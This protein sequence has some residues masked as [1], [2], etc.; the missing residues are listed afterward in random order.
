M[1]SK[2]I[3]VNLSLI[4]MIAILF[5][6]ATAQMQRLHM[7]KAVKIPF[8]LKHKD[9]VLKKGT[10]EFE[11]LR[12][13]AAPLH[14]LRIRKGGKKL[15]LIQGEPW[16]YS[17]STIGSDQLH[18]PNVPDDPRLRIKKIPEEKIVIITFETCKKARKYPF[19]RLRFKM[20]Y[21]E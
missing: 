17:T 18:D 8:K 16:T 19:I 20:E 15:C 9:T 11:F 6:P 13:L 21:E 10:Y 12:L 2:R 4:F 5:C 14:F 3:F 1:L 7:F